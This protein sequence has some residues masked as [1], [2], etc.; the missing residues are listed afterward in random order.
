METRNEETIRT[1]AY[2][3]WL[4]RGAPCNYTQDIDWLESER[5]ILSRSLDPVIDPVVS[6]PVETDSSAE[7]PAPP[8]VTGPA[9]RTNKWMQAHWEQIG[10]K[11]LKQLCLP[12]THDSGTYR[13]DLKLAPDAADL[14]KTLY[15]YADTENNAT[16]VR[17]YIRGMAICQSLTI[18]EQLDIGIRVIDLRVCKVD[19]VYYCC[20]ALL[21]DE[22]RVLLKDMAEFLA[23]NPYEVVFVKVGLKEM[24]VAEETEAWSYLVSHTDPYGIKYP[25]EKVAGD[26]SPL[27]PDFSMETLASLKANHDRRCLLLSDDYFTSNYSDEITTTD[28][29]ISRLES[30]TMEIEGE[31]RANREAKRESGKPTAIDRRLFEAQCFRPTSQFNYGAGYIQ[32]EGAISL[33]ALAGLAGLSLNYVPLLKTV[34]KGDEHT[35]VPANLHENAQNSRSIVREYFT[36][37]A[38]NPHIA[39]PQ[40]INCDYFQEV[41][42]VDIAIQISIGQPVPDLSGVQDIP[43]PELRMDWFTATVGLVPNLVAFAA[44]LAGVGCCDLGRYLDDNIPG[45]TG[46]VL[47]AALKGAGY[48]CGEVAQTI[49][50]V[51]KLTADE[52]N[53]V[54]RQIGYASDEIEQAFVNMGEGFVD[55]FSDAGEEAERI[56]IDATRMAE[57]AARIAAAETARE[58]ERIALETARIAEE[59]ARATANALNPSRW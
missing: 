27:D 42:L 56:A 30:R 55:F 16:G 45:I 35:P 24:S 17:K 59:A 15:N 2:E 31:E 49:H 43:V 33:G 39:R 4:N 1:L 54:L 19:G 20:H 21:G 23:A 57:E 51:L 52:L 40:V 5:I 26:D 11:P 13:L 46:D 38:G 3:L 47:G 36:W 29:V 41:P 10:F 14:I 8:E 37:L 34:F 6:E 28:G 50:T 18:R 7:V 32:A 53:T 25:K 44:M 58:A 22:I 48:A 12:S 9:R